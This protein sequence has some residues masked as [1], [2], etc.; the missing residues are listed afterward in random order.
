MQRNL[1][2]QLRW[3]RRSS[4]DFI[5]WTRLTSNVQNASKALAAWYR[6]RISHACATLEM[7]AGR[8]SKTTQT[9]KVRMEVHRISSYFVSSVNVSSNRFHSKSTQT[10]YE[11][12]KWWVEPM[13]LAIFSQ[14]AENQII[15]LSNFNVWKICLVMRTC[16]S[17]AISTFTVQPMLPMN[18]EVKARNRIDIQR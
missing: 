10:V 18:F 8:Q 2:H 12:L 11:F 16:I 13:Q 17:S 5:W 6:W 1:S 3:H 7:K 4:I 15:R 9:R 14:H